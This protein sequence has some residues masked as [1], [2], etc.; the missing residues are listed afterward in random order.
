MV[1]WI[2]GRKTYEMRRRYPQ[3]SPHTLAPSGARVLSIVLSSSPK[4]PGPARTGPEAFQCSDWGEVQRV[5][6]S[7]RQRLHAAWNIGGPSVYGLQTGPSV[8]ED[9]LGEVHL[10]RIAGRRFGCDLAYPGRWLLEA[11]RLEED[12]DRREQFEEEG[13]TYTCHVYYGPKKTK[14]K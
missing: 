4:E 14:K 12:A 10:T 5:L 3:N 2:M 1:A 13:I 8:W 11:G 6:R 9:R 7:N